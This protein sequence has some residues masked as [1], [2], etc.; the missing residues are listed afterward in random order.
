MSLGIPVVASCLPAWPQPPLSLL[1]AK[2]CQV[3]MAAL[4]LLRGLFSKRPT[5]PAVGPTGPCL[6]AGR[7]GL[8]PICHALMSSS[9]KVGK[10]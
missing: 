2:V 5:L 3:M 4:E 6:L 8:A 1:P 9:L 10:S 7:A